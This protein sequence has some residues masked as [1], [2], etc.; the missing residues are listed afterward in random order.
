MN[1]FGARRA[2][3]T[4]VH[5]VAWQAHHITASKNRESASHMIFTVNRKHSPGASPKTAT[6]GRAC[7]DV[8]ALSHA[9][10]QE[11]IAAQIK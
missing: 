2:V 3:G 11:C 1:A 5:A 9:R 4:R 8:A 6:G 7:R 10:V